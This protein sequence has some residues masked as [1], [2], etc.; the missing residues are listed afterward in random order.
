[1]LHTLLDLSTAGRADTAPSTHRGIA[2]SSPGGGAAAT[3]RR[4]TCR[5]WAACV[6]HGVLPSLEVSPL[7]LLLHSSYTPLTLLLHSAYLLTLLLHCSYT[8]LTYLH[9]SYTALTLLLHSSYTPLTLL[10]HNLHACTC[11]L[12]ACTWLRLDACPHTPP[13][14]PHL[15]RR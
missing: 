14:P 8:A 10:L 11:S 7:T 5:A 4:A 3:R 13:A 9:C 6:R 1:M 12:Y 2:A 15:F